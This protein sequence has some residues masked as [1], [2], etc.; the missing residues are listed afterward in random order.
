MRDFDVADVE[1]SMLTLLLAAEEVENM[2]FE[3]PPGF[4]AR[5]TNNTNVTAT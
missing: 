4:Y 2:N 1:L 3:H 5:T